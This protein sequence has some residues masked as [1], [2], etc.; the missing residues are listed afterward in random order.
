M[1]PD[2]RKPQFLYLTVPVLKNVSTL[3][4]DDLIAW[5]SQILAHHLHLACAQYNS[6]LEYLAI[7]NYDG[8]F[9]IGVILCPLSQ[10]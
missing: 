3:P 9:M 1:Q 10:E 5:I 4:A 8:Y 2:L 7:L 6:N